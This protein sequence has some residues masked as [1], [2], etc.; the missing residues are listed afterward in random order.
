MSSQ[1]NLFLGGGGG[2][3]EGGSAHSRAFEKRLLYTLETTGVRVLILGVLHSR[4]HKIL[5]INHRRAL[6]SRAQA[7]QLPSTFT[8]V[9]DL[10]NSALTNLPD[11]HFL[12][13]SNQM[14]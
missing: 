1:K 6:R 3:W 5:I 11:F 10:N 14:I 8:Q 2:G 7:A 9:G 4:E 12:Y 13:S